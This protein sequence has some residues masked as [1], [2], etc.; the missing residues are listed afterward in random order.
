MK[1]QLS[2]R[3]RLHEA[4]I[5]IWYEERQPGQGFKFQ[6][7]L[8]REYEMIRRFPMIFREWQEGVRHTTMRSFPYKIYF[9]V[10]EDR[11]LIVAIL[12][13]ARHPDGWSEEP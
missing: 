2:V 12:H 13:A 10:L 1:L 4:E 11:V 3:A 5:A 9:R 7:A 8:L 6:Q